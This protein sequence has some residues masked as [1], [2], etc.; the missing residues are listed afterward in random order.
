MA[1]FPS[2]DGTTLHETVWSATGTAKGAVVI[3]H[4]YFEHGA[5]YAHVGKAWAARGWNVHGLDFR[6]H[7]QSGG[8][9]GF[10]K[11][12]DEYL[13]DTDAALAHARLDGKPLFL[14]GHSMGAL[15]ATE[16]VLHR[17]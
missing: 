10:V 8:L 9:R 15:V 2:R 17:P 4:G 12:F 13:D 11:R 5:R 7:G 6:G 3:V 14:V 1:N 16:Y